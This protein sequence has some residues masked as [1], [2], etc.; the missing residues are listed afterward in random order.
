MQLHQ[1][2]LAKPAKRCN[3]LVLDGVGHSVTALTLLE[4]ISPPLLLKVAEGY[5]LL[6]ELTLFSFN[7]D[8][9]AT[10]SIPSV[11]VRHEFH[12]T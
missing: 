12:N 4:S 11:L 5:G 6:M 8:A 7:D 10:H 1:Y 3:S 9:V 2:K